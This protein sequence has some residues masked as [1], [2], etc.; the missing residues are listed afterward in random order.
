M[1]VVEPVSAAP[2]GHPAVRALRTA[3]GTALAYAL[4][5]WLALQLRVPPDYAIVVFFPAGVA[6]GAV[7]TRGR[8]ALPGVLLGSLAVQVMAHQAVGADWRHWGVLI[9]ALG[10]A[11]MAAL[12]AWAVR[13]W[14]GYPSALDEPHQVLRLLFGVLPAS[15]LLN[16]SVSV[17]ALVLRGVIAPGDALG[18]WASWW[19]GDT[20]GATLLV[21]LVLVL[22]GEPRAAWWGRRWG[23]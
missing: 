14:V 10:A 11:A 17:P 1:D 23:V 3:A 16:A 18:Q 20:L 2:P 15:S 4:A 8:A 13:R 9:P 7:L 6:A 22:L 21:P 19:I 12:S 5:G